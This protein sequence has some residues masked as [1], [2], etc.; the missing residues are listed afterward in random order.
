MNMLGMSCAYSIY[1]SVFQYTFGVA[2]I[3]APK[4]LV[5]TLLLSHFG[6]MGRR[7]AYMRQRKA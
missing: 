5:V 4:L 7:N 6:V 3:L 1:V 2:E